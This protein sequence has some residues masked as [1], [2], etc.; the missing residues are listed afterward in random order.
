[1]VRVGVHYRRDRQTADISWLSCG[2]L[3]VMRTF[4]CM[5]QSEEQK[6]GANVRTMK[7]HFLNVANDCFSLIKPKTHLK[8]N[9]KLLKLLT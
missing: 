3:M 6:N 5:F 1:M 8:I 7:A 4:C 9:P 2:M